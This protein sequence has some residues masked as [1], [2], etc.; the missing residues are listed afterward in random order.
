MYYGYSYENPK[1]RKSWIRKSLD[2]ISTSR[3]KPNINGEKL[4]CVFGRVSLGL[5]MMGCS[6]QTKPLLGPSI[7]YTRL[8]WTEHRRK[9][10]YKPN[11]IV[12]LHSN[13]RQE[14][15]GKSSPQTAPAG[16]DLSIY[17]LFSYRWYMVHL[18]T[19]PDH[20]K[21]PKF[22]SMDGLNRLNMLPTRCL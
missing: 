9:N 1:K 6:N 14:A 22:R 10:Y 4:C 12:F 16:Y 21:I 7:E 11:I 19:T 15:T 17:L 2:H 20:M 5:C 13:A 8:D 3:A 18:S